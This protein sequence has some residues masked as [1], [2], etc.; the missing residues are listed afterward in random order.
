MSENFVVKSS[1]REVNSSNYTRR[2]RKQGI[3]PGVVYGPKENFN[4]SLIKKDFEKVFYKV[5]EHTVLTLQIEK[6]KDKKVL[7]HDY[8]IDPVNKHLIHVDFLMVS[9]DRP[10]HTNVPI[11]VIG[12]AKG[13]KVGGIL[14]Q[15]MTFLKIKALPKD[16]PHMF[17]VDVTE[18]EVATSIKVKDLK[19]PTGVTVLNK[20]DQSIVG[21]VTSRATKEGS[22][23]TE[24]TATTTT[25][26][27]KKEDA[28]KEEPKKEDKAKSKK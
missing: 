24:E 2:L 1:K 16:I 5:G 17:E 4:I 8:Q 7:I 22:T 9:D 21:V 26:E 15:F 23:A 14:E 28:K 27:A 11:K 19:V 18:L 20:P 6:E 12:S 3:L 13:V 10:V 25:E